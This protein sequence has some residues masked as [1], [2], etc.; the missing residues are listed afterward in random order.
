MKIKR[1]NIPIPK[2][3]STLR[4]KLILGFLIPIAFIILLG[5]VSFRM[6]ST[7]IVNKYKDTATQVIGMTGEYIGFGIDAIEST[8]LEYINDKNIT[9]FISGYYKGG[10]GEEITARKTIQNDLMVKATVDDFILNIH[11]VSDND[12]SL[13]SKSGLI[14][15][16]DIYQKFI[17]TDTGKKV[18]EDKS[19]PKWFGS[20]AFLDEKLNTNDTD[21]AMRMIQRYPNN[22]AFVVIDVKSDKIKK[23]L[24]NNNLDESGILAFTTKDGKEIA[25]NNKD[26]VFFGEQTFYLKAVEGDETQGSEYVNIKNET[27]LFMYSK[28]G[29]TGAMICAL[30]PKDIITSQADNIKRVTIIIV[31][32]AC[33][34][35]V[36]IGGLIS[37]GIDKTITGIISKLKKA[38][39]GDLTV[40]F[41]TNRH[42]EFKVLVEEIQNTTSNMKN[43]IGQV[44]L[45][46]KVVS[47]SSLGVNDTSALFLKSTEDISYAIREIEQGIMQQAKDAEEC[48]MQMDNLSK[49]IEMVSDNTKEISHITDNA[50]QSI[51][52]GTCRTQELNQQTRSTIIITTD[53][54]KAIETLAQK[55]KSITQI[56]NAINEI[57]NQTNLLSLNASIEAA[58]A[59]EYGKGFAVVADEIRNLAEQSQNSVKEIQKIIN[60][61]QSDTKIAVEAAKKAESALG[62]QESAVNNTIESYDHIN[63]TVGELMVHLGYISE[64]VESMEGSRASTLGAIENIS[65]VLEEVAASAGTVNQNASEQINSVGALNQ[66]AGVLSKNAEELSQAI[67]KFIV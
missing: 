57:A 56:T 36:F 54:V 60:S 41:H 1:K 17:D 35:A 14:I 21:Y 67:Q 11:I 61:I 16:S 64:N 12:T 48:L 47:D 23:I 63:E 59:G 53:I 45:L 29:E 62:L 2:C 55:S 44:N 19:K 20:D 51:A 8:S 46:S 6:A 3:F 18:K 52:E 7:G 27:Y 26:E 30:M 42:D 25:Y 49:K 37:T 38:A 28:I 50:K 43:L 65:A 33:I 10:R 66:S 9:K 4:F 40:E 34:I 31:I 32:V 15:E 24:E 13:T 58:R 22:K 39:Q 5:V